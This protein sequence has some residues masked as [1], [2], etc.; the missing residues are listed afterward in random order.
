MEILLLN[1]VKYTRGSCYCF[2]KRHSNPGVLFSSCQKKLKFAAL[3][4]WYLQESGSFCF[5]W[6]M[7]ASLPGKGCLCAKYASDQLH[8]V[9]KVDHCDLNMFSIFSSEY[10]I[11]NLCT[12]HKHTLSLLVH[13]IPTSWRLSYFIIPLQKERLPSKNNGPLSTRGLL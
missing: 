5:I 11:C 9:I 6:V 12:L 13:S 2:C 4:K 3:R 7:V 10:V 8:I 1:I